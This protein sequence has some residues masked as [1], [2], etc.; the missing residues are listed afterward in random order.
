MPNPCMLEKLNLGTSVSLMS[1]L[2]LQ[3]QPSPL[4]AIARSFETTVL[5]EIRIKSLLSAPFSP[6]AKS[7]LHFSIRRYTH[8]LYTETILFS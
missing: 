7:H 2:I 4:F 3:G 8:Q 6:I 1:F 5:E